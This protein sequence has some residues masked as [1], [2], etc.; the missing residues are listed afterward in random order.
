MIEFS[1][2]V[3][4]G[5]KREVFDAVVDVVACGRAAHRRIVDQH[6]AGDAD[7]IAVGAV[8]IVVDDV[9][10]ADVA[11]AA[12]DFFTAP[13][14]DVDVEDQ[15][16]AD[17]I[18][19]VEGDALARQV[20]TVSGGGDAADV[21]IARPAEVARDAQRTKLDVADRV[22]GRIDAEHAEAADRVI[23]VPGQGPVGGGVLQPWHV[24]RQDGL[25]GPIAHEDEI[26]RG[27]R[28]DHGVAAA[29]APGPGVSRLHIDGIRAGG[30]EDDA[31]AVVLGR[32]DRRANG[33]RV[34]GVAVPGRSVAL[35]V[36]H[37]QIRHRRDGL[38]SRRRQIAVVIREIRNGGRR[39]A[40]EQS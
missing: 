16:V 23:R 3:C 34:V 20:P 28:E 22:V 2:V 15:D 10:G 21:V 11:A 4:C 35:H 32:G 18:G 27:E 31:A 39:R 19:T 5:A 1:T 25:G 13:A 6:V 9:D 37:G 36:E 24:T 17:V 30:E 26:A 14:V 38:Q 12:V 29:V 8:E 33:D 7:G 40:E